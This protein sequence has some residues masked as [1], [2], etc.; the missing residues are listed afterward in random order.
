MADY[1]IAGSR[2]YRLLARAIYIAALLACAA[3]L[4]LALVPFGWRFGLW[5]YGLSFRMVAWAQDLA[6][7]GAVI[8]LLGLVF[9]RGAGAGRGRMLAVAIVLFGAGM[10][11][12]PY[13]LALERG[14]HP[15]INDITTD[16]ENPPAFAAALP[17]REAERA[18]PVV[19]G[20]A[21]VARQQQASYPD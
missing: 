21:A 14:P 5:H 1:A 11:A 6:L 19:Y 9:G 10:I 13:L 20:G 2:G 16:T 17:A 15:S 3:L 4:L 12:V 7:A 18:R 8:A